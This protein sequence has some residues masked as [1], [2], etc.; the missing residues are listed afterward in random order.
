MR[1]IFTYLIVWVLIGSGH[2]I[3]QMRADFAYTYIQ[4]PTCVNSAEVYQIQL[5]GRIE[6][7][8][9]RLEWTTSSPESVGIF[10]QNSPTPFLGVNYNSFPRPTEIEVTLLAINEETGDSVMVSKMVDVEMYISPV[11]YFRPMTIEPSFAPLTVK[12]EDHSYPVSGKSISKREWSFGDGFKSQDKAPE[13]T[14]K[15]PG[16]YT[17]R[18]KVTDDKGC[19]ALHTETSQTVVVHV[20]DPDKTEDTEK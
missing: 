4:K 15:V 12:F 17:V 6:G 1:A 11:I 13:H 2:V 5:N 9:T 7:H 20:L 14:Y 18:L 3:G 19:G 10:P 16:K 8:Y